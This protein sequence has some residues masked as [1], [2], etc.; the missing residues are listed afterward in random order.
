MHTAAAIFRLHRL[1][2]RRACRDTERFSPVS[3]LLFDVYRMAGKVADLL[4]SWVLEVRRHVGKYFGM[5]VVATLRGS[6]EGKTM[7]PRADM[8]VL[9]IREQTGLPYSSRKEGVMHACGH[10]VHTAMQLGATKALSRFGEQLAGT[11]KFVFQPAE[12]GTLPVPGDDTLISGGWDMVKDGILDGVDLCYALHVWPELPVGTLGVHP[13]RVPG[14]FGFI[15]AGN[16]ERSIVHSIHHPQFDVDEKVLL[17]H[18]A[19]IRVQTVM[20]ASGITN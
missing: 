8:D 19:R 13:T 12:E 16:A 20:Q 5:G 11:V 2:R 14:A 7:L 10:D 6:G 9:P 3:E 17:V 15:G 1:D 4:E 18:G